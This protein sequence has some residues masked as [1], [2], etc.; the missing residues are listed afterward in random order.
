MSMEIYGSQHD[1]YAEIYHYGVKGMRWGVR[2]SRP[3]RIGK[4]VRAQGWSSKE[5][6]DQRAAKRMKKYGGNKT[7]AYT[8]AV[9][10]GLGKNF[11]QGMGVGLMMNVP[12]ANLAAAPT[13]AAATVGTIGRTAQDVRAIKRYKD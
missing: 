4:A 3:S 5:E 9:V 13:A 11:V 12:V 2:R 10:T 7:K 8:A 1:G 6:A